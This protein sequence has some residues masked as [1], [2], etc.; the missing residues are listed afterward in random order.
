MNNSRFLT[1]SVLSALLLGSF[2]IDASAFGLKGKHHKGGHGKKMCSMH[3]DGG[4]GSKGAHGKKNMDAKFSQRAH[5]ILANAEEIGLSDEQKNTLTELMSNTKKS[6]IRAKADI[7]IIA[8]DIHTGLNTKKPDI[9]ALEGLIDQ[10]Y[11]KKKEQAK[12]L[13]RALAQTKTLLT[14]DQWEKLKKIK[15]DIH[16]RHKKQ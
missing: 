14:A 7:E 2:S 15:K 5:F 9:A 16:G 12:T 6:A 11:E 10:K 13:V 1:L 4:H 3:A 8:L